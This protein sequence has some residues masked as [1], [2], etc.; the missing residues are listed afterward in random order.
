MGTEYSRKYIHDIG[1]ERL[2]CH[3]D[4]GNKIYILKNG[5]KYKKFNPDYADLRQQVNRNF[6]QDLLTQTE[7]YGH[8]II[9]FPEAVISSEKWLSGM[10]TDFASGDKLK[11]IDLTTQIDYLLYIIEQLEQ[12]IEDISLR[13]WVLEDLHE[14]NI[15][16]DSS[17]HTSP[18]HIIDTDFYAKH[19]TQDQILLLQ[20][21]KD[22]LA[23]I[24]DA[25]M[26][27]ILP[28]FDTSTIW[29]DPK[30]Q[31]TY[32]KAQAGETTCSNFLKTLLVA[33]KHSQQKE[34]N[35]LTLRKSIM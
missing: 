30:I 21:Y 5:K 23:R 7:E 14:E 12:G 8:P 35:I 24:F 13:G 2:F 17:N 19:Q 16:I 11:S 15:L 31:E 34:Q 32:M 9:C 3:T 6:K 28:K 33:L 25:I 27:T 4:M 22:N 10:I 20:T 18:V 29:K 26:Q 1:K